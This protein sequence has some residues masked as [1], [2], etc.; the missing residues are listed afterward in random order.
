MCPSQAGLLP[1]SVSSLQSFSDAKT[2]PLTCSLLTG[3]TRDRSVPM[4][5]FTFSA[6]FGTVAAPI[7][8]G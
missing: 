2:P 5:T 3:N 6:I 8:S 1:I 7:Y 4:S